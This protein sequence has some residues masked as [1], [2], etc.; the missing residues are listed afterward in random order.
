MRS[1]YTNFENLKS[2]YFLRPRQPILIPNCCALSMTGYDA[3]LFRKLGEFV[4]RT[5]HQIGAR[6]RKIQSANTTPKESISCDHNLFALY[7]KTDRAG[8]VPG[9][10]NHAQL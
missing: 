6:F 8:C 5:L 2:K 4:Q 10:V 9:R 1:F 7:I 3:C